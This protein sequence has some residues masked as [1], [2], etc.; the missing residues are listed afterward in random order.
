M[1]DL[2]KSILVSLNICPFIGNLLVGLNRHNND[3]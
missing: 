2:V 1:Y 3:V